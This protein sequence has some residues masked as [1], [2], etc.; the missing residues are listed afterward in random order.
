MA[1]TSTNNSSAVGYAGTPGGA[2]IEGTNS[3]LILHWNGAVWTQVPNHLA[4][5]L[6]NLRGVT[7]TSAGTAWAVGCIGCLVKGAG[8]P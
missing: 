7:A 1:A 4:P 3:P 6:G 5:G 2:G 8:D